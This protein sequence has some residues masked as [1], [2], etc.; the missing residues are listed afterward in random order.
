[1]KYINVYVPFTPLSLYANM[2]EQVS[3]KGKINQFI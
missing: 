1:M 3:K 2:V